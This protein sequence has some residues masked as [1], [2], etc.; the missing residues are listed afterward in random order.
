MSPPV[1][2][3]RSGQEGGSPCL[4]LIAGN[5]PEESCRMSAGTAAPSIEL[6]SVALPD[7]LPP[8]IATSSP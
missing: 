8:M 1:G 6:S 5:M 4:A 7:P 2:R 3:I